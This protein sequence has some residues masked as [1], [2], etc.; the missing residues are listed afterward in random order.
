MRIRRLETTHVSSASHMRHGRTCETHGKRD[1]GFAVPTCVHTPHHTYTVCSVV[2]D[3]NAPT[4]MAA[5]TRDSFGGSNVDC[6]RT[7]QHKH[8]DAGEDGEERV[9]ARTK[10]G[11]SV[12]GSL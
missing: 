5:H 7:E 12:Q 4:V 6:D 11:A 10:T 9:P 8:A 3:Q 2:M 1:G